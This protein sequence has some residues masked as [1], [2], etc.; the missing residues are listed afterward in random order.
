MLQA[1][2]RAARR[3][4]QRISFSG[5]EPTLSRD[6]VHYVSAASRLGVGKIELVTNGVLL[7]DPRR[8]RALRDAGLTEAFVS[9]H[10]HDERLSSVMTQKIGDHA[11]SVKAIHNLN[12]R[13]VD[14]LGQPRRQRAQ[15]PV[16]RALRRIRA[17]RVRRRGRRSRWRS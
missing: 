2:S 3:G 5:G 9:L 13:G 14:R 15:L 6:L 17:G 12:R 1:I 10:A 16:S 11:K 7:D 4:V 8:V